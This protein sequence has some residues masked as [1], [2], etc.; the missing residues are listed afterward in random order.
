MSFHGIAIS[1]KKGA[2]KDTLAE[3]LCATRSG[4]VITR[5]KTPI[6]QAYERIVGHAYDKSRDDADL[7]S[8]SRDIIRK[9]N[10][11]ICADYLAEVFPIILR[12]RLIPVIPDMRRL[13]EYR[14]LRDNAIC[15]KVLCDEKVRLDRIIQREGSLD[16]YDP[17]DS[18]E[19]DVDS[20]ACPYLVDNSKNDNGESAFSQI[21]AIFSKLCIFPKRG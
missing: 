17:N 4:M 15:V 3:Y 10:D 12:E 8:V 19:K 1:G 2:G 5:C 7:I 20:I 9:E 11:E 16:N 21:E 6:V 14:Y 13:P 18:T